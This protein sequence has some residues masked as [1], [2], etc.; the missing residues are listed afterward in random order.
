MWVIPEGE[1]CPSEYAFTRTW[2]GIS[3]YRYGPLVKGSG[4]KAKRRPKYEYSGN[5]PI[6]SSLFLEKASFCVTLAQSKFYEKVAT[7]NS[8]GTFECPEGSVPCSK[9]ALP[10]CISELD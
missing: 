1:I 4:K 7:Q 9:S 3:Y 6:E 2:H 5:G 10:V 8:H